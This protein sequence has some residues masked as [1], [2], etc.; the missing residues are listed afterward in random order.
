M[1]SVLI[2]N[3]AAASYDLTLLATVKAEIGL[4]TTAEDTKLA[5]WIKQ[6]SGACAAYCNRVLI[7]ETVTETFRNKT[8]YPL[9]NDSFRN[10]DKIVLV[11]NPVVS[12]T[13]I[14]L[15]GV[16][17]VADVDYQLDPAEGIIY[18]L[19]PSNDSLS[20]WYFKKLV[21]TYSGG[22]VLGTTLETNIERACISYVVMLR[23]SAGRDASVKQESI[24]GVLETQ[25]WVGGIGENGALSPD[26]TALLDPYRNVSI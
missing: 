20:Y 7:A 2:V 10:V 14:V 3:T 8:S 9:R 17:L 5:T 1:Q 11:R 13:S 19:D 6:A 24:P 22:Y 21:V 16:T 12:I 25:Y 15:D 26:V 23:S 4:T 18:R